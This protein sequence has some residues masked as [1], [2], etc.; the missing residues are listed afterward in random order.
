M[1]AFACWIGFQLW[2][3]RKPAISN[4]EKQEFIATQ[5]ITKIFETFGEWLGTLLAIIG[6]GVGLLGVIF[7]GDSM[8]YL[9]DA[10]GMGFMQLGAAVIIIW[11]VLGFFIIILFKFL[12]EQLRILAALANNTKE[13]AGNIKNNVQEK[14]QDTNGLT[15]N[16]TEGV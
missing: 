13:I 5:Q 8:D 14:P 11:P 7:L 12:A 15:A 16:G 6:V 3:N 2:W 4:A 1:I 9:F 10:M